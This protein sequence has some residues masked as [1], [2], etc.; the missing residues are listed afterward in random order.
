MEQNFVDRL[1]EIGLT[2]RAACHLGQSV[3]RDKQQQGNRTDAERSGQL[4]FLLG[5][6]LVDRYAVAVLGSQFFEDRS[7]RFTG[8]APRSVEIDEG[9]FVAEVFPLGRV[10]FVI[11]DFLQKIRLSQS[12]VVIFFSF[13]SL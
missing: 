6:H 1:P 5:V 13:L 11:G 8:A 9:G 7:H 4:R 12:I 2:H 10:S 3:H